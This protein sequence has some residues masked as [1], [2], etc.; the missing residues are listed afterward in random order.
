MAQ[1]EAGIG[2]EV[3]RICTEFAAASEADA[4]YV[5]APDHRGAATAW[6]RDVASEAQRRSN[7]VI[8]I[9][10]L[11]PAHWGSATRIF[12]RPHLWPTGEVDEPG[13]IPPWVMARFIDYG[14]E[15][16]CA[17][18]LS[19]AENG[20]APGAS[21]AA[22]VMAAAGRGMAAED[23]AEL[24]GW[25]RAGGGKIPGG[26]RV[27]WASSERTTLP[28]WTD[29]ACAEART[30]HWEL[31]GAHLQPP[32]GRVR[33]LRVH[34]G[35]RPTAAEQEYLDRAARREVLDGVGD[36]DALCIRALLAVCEREREL[37][38]GR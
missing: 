8:Y 29:L 33:A 2:I 24:I 31:C 1:E 15:E 11:G 25:A 30:R 6:R 19:R 12:H 13:E 28:A 36:G 32:E 3:Y 18:L 17:D 14:L 10:W 9:S 22:F 37:I 16:S 21:R 20:R 38:L 23:I 5:A 4:I 35:P 7:G 26:R 34:S 27:H